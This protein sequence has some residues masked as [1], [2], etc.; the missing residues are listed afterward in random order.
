MTREQQRTPVRDGR[1]RV[2]G[3]QLELRVEYAYW[4]PSILQKLPWAKSN[5]PGVRADR[6]TSFNKSV[7][8]HSTMALFYYSTYG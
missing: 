4:I 8:P 5:S 6:I 7:G 2:A 3:V 1:S